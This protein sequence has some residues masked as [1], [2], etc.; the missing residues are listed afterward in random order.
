MPHGD[1]RAADDAAHPH[2]FMVACSNFGMALPGR[3]LVLPAMRGHIASGRGCTR[4]ARAHAMPSVRIALLLP[5][6]PLTLGRCTADRS[7]GKTEFKDTLF[8][9]ARLL[10]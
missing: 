7:S 10:F 1:P 9:N 6:A 8:C 5:A 4:V 3:L 2:A